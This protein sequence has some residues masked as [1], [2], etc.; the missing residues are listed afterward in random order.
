M[1]TDICESCGLLIFVR[2]VDYTIKKQITCIRVE[3]REHLVECIETDLEL[4]G[5]YAKHTRINYANGP[6]TACNNITS[7]RLC[8][9]TAQQHIATAI[10]VTSY[11][12]AV[13]YSTILTL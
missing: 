4:E 2:A 11:C 13:V 5:D 3:R 8:V 6:H 7:S 1:H 12:G 10:K 9:H